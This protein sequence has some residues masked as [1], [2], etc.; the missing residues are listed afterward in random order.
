MVKKLFTVITLAF[1]FASFSPLPIH[2]QTSSNYELAGGSI[3]DH[4]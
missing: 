1:V 3:R 4:P 2:A